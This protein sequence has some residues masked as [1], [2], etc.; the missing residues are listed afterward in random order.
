MSEVLLC[1]VP[2]ALLVSYTLGP[3]FLLERDQP[4][5]C[6]GSHMKLH[7]QSHHCVCAGR[8]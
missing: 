8:K 2:P 3:V 1:C 5:L 6:V 7:S 4:H